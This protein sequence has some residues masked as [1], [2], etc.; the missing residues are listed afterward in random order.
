VYA[1]IFLNN[2]VKSDITIGLPKLALPYLLWLGLLFITIVNCNF[3][4]NEVPAA[5]HR[6]TD[7]TNCAQMSDIH[8]LI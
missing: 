2:S 6:S 3:Q 8:T 7:I 4:A 5:L 1:L